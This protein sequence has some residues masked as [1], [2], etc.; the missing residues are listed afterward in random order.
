[1]LRSAIL[2]EDGRFRYRLARVW[3]ET[4]PVLAFV[5]LNPST[6]D[7]SVDDA[8]I[9]VCIAFAQRL[10]YGSIRVVNLY[11]YRTRWPRELRA[12]GWLVGQDNDAAIIAA[13]TDAGGRRVDVCC[14][15]G[16]L[17]YG[18]QR[19]DDVLALIRRYGVQ[20]MCLALSASGEPRHPLYLR[21]DLPLRPLP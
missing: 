12:A 19:R 16:A 4:L 21:R 2:S 11:A 15:W 20:P 5:M 17:A 8:T 9:R 14:A 1:M 3:D 13:I 7:D 18:L 6:A 10:G